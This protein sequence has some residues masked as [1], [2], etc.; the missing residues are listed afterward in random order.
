MN[1]PFVHLNVHSEYSLSDGIVR[2]KPLV[3]KLKQFGQ[4]AVALT[5]ISNLY[6]LVKLYKACLQNGIKPIIGVDVWIESPFDSQD[7]ARVKFF[8]QNAEGYRNLN[9][10]L[11]QAYLS[12]SRQNKPVIDW[13]NVMDHNE[14]LIIVCDDQQG[15]FAGLADHAL[16]DISSIVDNMVD[17]LS[18]TFRNRVYFEISRIGRSGEENYIRQICELSMRSTIPLLATN[19]VVYLNQEDF[20]AHEIR[21]CINDGRVLED[22][23][24]P[25]RFTDQ[26]YLRSSEEMQSLFSDLPEAL[27]NSVELSKR[28]NLFLNFDQDHLPDY[29]EVGDREVDD[30]LRDQ[31]E[32]GLCDRLGVDSLR[33][34]SGNALVDQS[35]LDRL[36]T[37]LNVV[38][39]M[40]FPG[41]FLIVADFIRWARN[42]DIPVGPGRGSGAG[43]LVAWATGITELDPLE[44]GLLFERFL[45]PERVSLP[46]FDIDFCVDGRDRVIEYVA[47][48]YGRDQVAQI[49]TFGTMAAKAVV[50]DVGR[51]MSLPYGFVDQIAK[52]IPFEIGMT[53][54][55][56]L[57]QE[58]PLR[59]RYQ[60]DADIQEL[61]DM[62]L[63]L[64][65][66]ARN[67][68]KHAGG[69]VIA[70]RALTEYTPLY[71]DSHLNQAITQLDKDDLESI[72]LVKFDFLGLRTL[73][74]LDMAVKMVN[75]QKH[76]VGD[77]PLDLDSVP[78]DDEKTFEL[79][80]AGKTTAIF[81]LESRGMKELIVRLRPDAFEDLVALVALFRP[82]PLQSGMVDDFINRK[83]GREQVKYPH[84]DV[85]PLLKPTYGVILYQEQVMQIAQVLAGF[86]LGGADLLRRAMG[87][88]KPEEMAK[89]RELFAEG[90]ANRGVDVETAEYIFDLMEKFAGYGFN[91]SHSAAYALVSY[92]TAWLKTHYP[93]AFMAATMST[94]LS[95]TDNVV[96]L[97]ADSSDMGLEVLP[98]DI[99][100]CEY[101]FKPVDDSCILYGLGAIRGVGEGVIENIVE[102]RERNGNFSSLFEFCSRLDT[103]RVN[104]RVLE[105][106]IR[107]GAMDH[108]GNHR[109]ELMHNV[110]AALQAAGKQQQD[111]E[112]G[113]FDL[114]GSVDAPDV[115]QIN[116]SVPEWSKEQRLIAE[117]ETLGLY[118]TGHPYDRFQTELG[119]FVDK[120][121]DTMDLTKPRGGVF[122]GLVISMRVIN[123]RRG[124]MAFV[125]LDNSR[126]RIEVSLYSEKYNQYSDILQKDSVLVAQGEFSADEYTGGIQLR[127]ESVYDIKTLR[128]RFLRRITLMLC[129]DEMNSQFMLRLKTV[130]QE[131]RGGGIPVSIQ[132]QRIRGESGALELGSNWNLNANDGLM[133]SL[134]SA[135]GEANVVCDYDT[136]SIRSGLAEESLTTP[137]YAA[138]G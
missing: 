111:R 44:Y 114:F 40:G 13:L 67:V 61:I 57:D 17:V 88:K 129:E 64:E 99:N 118:L 108:L 31:S 6:A 23:R 100:T 84:P 36:E 80:Q 110:S 56:A 45:N 120:G 43:S 26:Q 126:R 95:N 68:G 106:L 34:E 101:R 52:M 14:G 119:A 86:T 79:I 37:E 4:P 50:R 96:S 124:K 11:T 10:L 112:A 25:R 116:K 87:K 130:L 76:R 39:Q 2:I 122:A 42:N 137:E 29:P 82:G 121:F 62:A 7:N 131:F 71:A 28:C 66:I 94:D 78:L 38:S 20:E 48:R 58:E 125:V 12:G 127:A 65:G 72:G 134:K 128:N 70:P 107:S 133:R 35:Y 85:E 21:V 132:Y 138:A 69:V 97:L 1:H 135:F 83:H 5:D 59:D 24:R 75:S 105:A 117:K 18:R 81:Q 51:V 136:R 30:V 16:A 91:K 98:P 113:Q 103:R 53:L 63:Q 93:A 74:I 33:D 77:S 3:Q 60:S 73:T 32:K 19:R 49:I 102:E 123:T 47:E 90:A 41:Y 22:S 92:H 46:D 109:A 55:K 9:Y 15:P 115:T 27:S 8:C 104:K 89:Q 54:Q